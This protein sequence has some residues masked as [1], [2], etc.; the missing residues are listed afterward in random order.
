MKQAEKDFDAF[1]K[2][3]AHFIRAMGHPARVAV[4]LAMARRGREIEGETVDIPAISPTTVQHRKPTWP[5]RKD[6]IL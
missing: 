1:E 6:F 2:E 4:L 3:L 5:P